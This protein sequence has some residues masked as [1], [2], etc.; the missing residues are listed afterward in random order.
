MTESQFPRFALLSF[1]FSPIDGPCRLWNPERT[2]R[3]GFSWRS[4]KGTPAANELDP[5]PNC[6][7]AGLAF[8]QLRRT[9]RLACARPNLVTNHSAFSHTQ[10]EDLPE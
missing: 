9:P 7:S 10:S 1:V 3:H 5:N 6:F 2:V 4:R 8:P